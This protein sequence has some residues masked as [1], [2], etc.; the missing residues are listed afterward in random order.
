MIRP[1]LLAAALLAA[2]PTAPALARDDAPAATV[3][4][5]IGADLRSEEVRYGAQ[6]DDVLSHMLTADVARAAA[7]GGFS[8][9]DL[10]IEY[11]RPNRPTVNQLALNPGL[12]F[13]SLAVGG[14]TI[15]GSVYGADGVARPL[16]FSWYQSDFGEERGAGIWYDADRAFQLLS[17]ELAHGR[18]S[19]RYS[20]GRL[21][22]RPYHD[23]NDAF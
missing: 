5:A 1:A 20:G 9:L 6:E 13:E 8:R 4:V 14:A 3:N 2:P 10:V 22:P 17:V 11:A 16:K 21:G 15:S 12:S 23:R 18:V 7:K 19:D